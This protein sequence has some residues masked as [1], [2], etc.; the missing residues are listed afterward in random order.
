MR[1]ILAVLIFMAAATSIFA[2]YGGAR[3]AEPGRIVTGAPGIIVSH[4]GG[5]PSANFANRGGAG[6]AGRGYYR[7]GDRQ[8]AHP[9][10][11]STV[12]V[13]VPVMVGGGYYYDQPAPPP[14]DG[15]Y[16]DPNAGTQGG[17]PPVVII[18]QNFRPETVNPVLRDYSQTDLPQAAD[19]SGQTLKTYENPTHPYIDAMTGVAQ[20]APVD[21][22]K[23]TIIL[24]AFK[25]HTI[26]PALALW[27]D[28]DALNYITKDGSQNRVSLA[29]ID[30]DFSQQLNDERHVEFKLPP[31]K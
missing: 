17:T 25:D 2:Q 19:Q 14:P 28:G 15:Y 1:R 20:A 5:I 11:P 26:V 6:V 21:D 24:I 23:P 13:P 18:N 3:G 10:H 7:G 30:R 9:R 22:E 31:A 29:L 8:V 4:P 27:A 12:I 16:G